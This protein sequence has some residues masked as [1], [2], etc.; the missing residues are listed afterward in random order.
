MS[1]KTKLVQAAIGD[2][3]ISG[4]NPRIV[5][6]KS[7]DFKELCESIAAMG[8][9]EPVH[10]RSDTSRQKKTYELLAG[11]RRLRA[12]INAGL[13]TIPALDHG[14]IPD[15]RAFEI[16]FAENFCRQDLTVLEHGR[17]VAIL[18]KKYNSD[19]AAVAS[20][21][22][23]SERWVR[24]HECIETNLISDFK[25]AVLAGGFLEYMTA[26]HLELIARFPSETQLMIYRKLITTWR[27]VTV[28]VDCIERMANGMLRVISKANFDT[29][30]CQKCLKRSGCQPMLWADDEKKPAGYDKCLDPVCWEKKAIKHEKKKFKEKAEKKPGLI[31]VA[32]E[33]Y[34]G[35]DEGKRLRRIYGKVLLK[36]DFKVCKK[37]DK[38]AVPAVVVAGSGKKNIF[39]KVKKTAQPAK[40]AKKSK[41]QIAAEL[42]K[43]RRAETA[44]RIAAKMSELKFDDIC[45]PDRD[46]GFWRVMLMVAVYGSDCVPTG[47]QLDYFET[48]TKDN[49]MY[50]I[51]ADIWDEIRNNFYVLDQSGDEDSNREA[52][53]LAG[54]FGLDYEA[55][56]KEVCNEDGSNI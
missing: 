36:R 29:S 10:V 56:Y 6:V 1:K 40:P 32:N 14:D 42:K 50:D 17:A 45:T 54:L 23:K 20:K 27:G 39:V 48:K 3:A 44:G 51:A 49:I 37:D 46:G 47:S 31:A 4:D 52:E 21:L 26:A 43:K 8:V 5:D 12:A 11:E 13:G 25:T 19:Y 7:A 30:K 35:R 34:F 2:I 18:L 9:I 41:K 24:R 55:V 28:S 53:L 16:T 15:S 33:H 22:G 38:G